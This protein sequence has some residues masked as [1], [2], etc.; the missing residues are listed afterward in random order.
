MFVYTR[1]FRTVDQLATMAS[2]NLEEALLRLKELV[3]ISNQPVAL[4]QGHE[5]LAIGYMA[6][7]KVKVAV[8]D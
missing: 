5:I 2:D 1:V 8:T 6:N 7:G 4:W 3:S